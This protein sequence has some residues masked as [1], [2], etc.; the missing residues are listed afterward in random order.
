MSLQSDDIRP[1]TFKVTDQQLS[2]VQKCLDKHLE[3]SKDDEAAALR[4]VQRQIEDVLHPPFRPGPGEPGPVYL[5]RDLWD[6]VK[7]LPTW[8]GQPINEVDFV[9]V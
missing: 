2:L 3:N 6:T 9:F 1:I 5:A 7:T 8:N 4:D